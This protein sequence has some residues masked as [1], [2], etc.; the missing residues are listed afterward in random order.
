MPTNWIINTATNSGPLGSPISSPK[1]VPT[2]MIVL[3][4][5]L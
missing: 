4:A 3:T 5:S 1:V 2:R